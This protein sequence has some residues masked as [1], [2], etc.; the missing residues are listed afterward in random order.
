[1]PN[2]FQQPEADWSNIID[3]SA[4]SVFLFSIAAAV[5]CYASKGAVI[6]LT[7]SLA[8]ELAPEIVVNAIAPGP[9]LV[10]TAK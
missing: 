8:L 9:I 7:E 2:E 6:A 1:V 10:S 3:A 5:S 4:R